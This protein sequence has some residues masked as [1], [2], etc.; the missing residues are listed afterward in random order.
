ML[1]SSKKDIKHQQ[2][3]RFTKWGQEKGL[4][5]CVNF[6]WFMTGSKIFLRTGIRVVRWSKRKILRMILIKYG[7]AMWMWCSYN[8]LVILK[9]KGVNKNF[10]FTSTSCHTKVPM[11][12]WLL[13]L[14]WFNWTLIVNGEKFWINKSFI[15]DQ[16]LIGSLPDYFLTLSITYQNAHADPTNLHLT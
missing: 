12:G 3:I 14:I 11:N 15:Q 6:L 2:H 10:R 9:P 7:R 16:I 4:M 8:N 1:N 5:D 13:F